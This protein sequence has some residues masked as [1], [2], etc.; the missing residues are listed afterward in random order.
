[1]DNNNIEWY[2]LIATLIGGG[3]IGAIITA[4]VTKYR[5]RKQPIGKIIKIENVFAPGN[6]VSE[7]LTKITFS[8]T[9]ET[10]HYDNL[11]LVQVLIQNDGNKDFDEFTFGLTFPDFAKA[12][13][14]NAKG[15][16][17]HHAIL[18]K[19]KIDFGSSS[20][21]ADFSLRPFNRH[22]KYQILIYATCDNNK[23]LE[24]VKIS[25]QMPVIFKDIE[26]INL[27]FLEILNQTVT[28]TLG[29]R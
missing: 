23:T 3:A 2:K 17:R 6:L 4:I 9:T 14:V 5:G 18:S 7:H 22:D 15:E 12:I 29:S 19:E 21:I 26:I 25:S 13:K 11:Y 10:F 27:S 16:D 24:E 1:M 8:G 28:L 20:S